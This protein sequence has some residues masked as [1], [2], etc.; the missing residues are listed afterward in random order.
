MLEGDFAVFY[1]H[2]S[3]P[4]ASAMAGF[5]PRDRA[6]HIAHRG[7]IMRDDSTTLRTVLCDG[8]VAGSI[9]SWGGD[10]GPEVGY[11]IGKSFWNNGIATIALDEFLRL[12]IARPLFAHVTTHN[13]A[14]IRVLEKCGFTGQ[15]KDFD[16]DTI[17]VTL[18]PEK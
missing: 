5:P 16:A 9:V 3:D 10:G 13:V 2:Q 18:S 17:E 12:L 15:S 1:E 7:K 11:W 8:E 6:A 14:S 4:E